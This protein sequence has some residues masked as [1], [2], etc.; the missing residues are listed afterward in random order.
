MN[1]HKNARLTFAR[2]LEMVRQ[3]TQDALTP[4]DA[5]AA[6]GV[7]EPTARKWLG[8]FLAGGEAA[9]ADASSRPAVSPRRISESR[10][11]AVV[12]LRRR[13]LTQARIAAS[14]GLSEA[15][16]S[17]VLR[18]AGLSKLASL[19]PVEP[20]QRYEH[21]APG[22]LLHIDTKKLGRIE[23]RSHRI[24]GNR[25]DSVNGAGWEM[26]F[27][28]IDDHARIG[29]T[30]MHP[31]ERTPAAVAFLRDAV[32]YYGRLGVRVQRLLT[33]NG[34]AFRSRAFRMACVELGIRHKFTRP[35]RPQTNGKA[36]RF[37]Q[38]ALREWAYGIAYDHS[39]ERTEM[40]AKWQHHY[41]W[42]RPHAGIGGKP[43]MSRLK[44]SSGNNV[45]T[46]HT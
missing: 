1:H 37:I 30:Q 39:T 3:M 6:A 44:P 8:R 15:T 28:A 34:S 14:L 43:P 18:R 45:L 10:A 36:E 26:L 20:V 13:R 4:A 29:F 25:R 17:R 42:H 33:D 40:L 32:A 12:E 9:L 41:N 19:Q 2:R 22:E 24:T 11:L 16:V 5:A 27:V 46:L 31:D 35:Y 21:A 38:S 23:R 7:S